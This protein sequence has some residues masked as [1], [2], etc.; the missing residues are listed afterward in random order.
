MPKKT[1]NVPKV[2]AKAKATPF[3]DPTKRRVKRAKQSFLSMVQAL[4][5]KS[6]PGGTTI[7]RQTVKRQTPDQTQKSAIRPQTRGTARL[8]TP[9]TVTSA[10]RNNRTVQKV[11]ASDIFDLLRAKMI[12]KS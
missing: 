2:K 3:L 10:L 1:K 12:A 4:N 11:L 8:R 5:Q 9:D 7:K 6:T